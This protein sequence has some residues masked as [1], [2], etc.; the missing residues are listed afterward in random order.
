MEADGQIKQT[1]EVVSELLKLQA[2]LEAKL[3][4]QE[5]RSRRD[6]IRIYRIAERSEN[7]SSTIKFIEELLKNGLVLDPMMD[8]HIQ[9]AHRALVPK[10]TDSAT[11]RSVIAKFLSFRTKEEICIQRNSGCSMK[12]RQCPIILLKRWQKTWRTEAFRWTSSD[13]NRCHWNAFS[14]ELGQRRGGEAVKL[15][16][17]QLRTMWSDWKLSDEN[18][19]K[20]SSHTD[21]LNWCKW[22]DNYRSAYH[23]SDDAFLLKL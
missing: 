13:H 18:N 4:D 3:T 22:Q 10:P 11:P 6:N 8:L 16:L 15:K 7:G 21:R 5:G 19:K 1:G 9:R 14:T 2:Q 17:I 12:A 20:L 23:R